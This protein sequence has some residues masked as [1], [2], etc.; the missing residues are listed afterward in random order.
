MSS[1]GFLMIRV[2]AAMATKLT[3]LKPV[4]RGLLVLRRHIIAVLTISALQHNIIAWHNSFPISDCRLP[5]VSFLPVT[6]TFDD[7]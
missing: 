5:I 7:R 3:K 4:W 2:L 1:L 6:L